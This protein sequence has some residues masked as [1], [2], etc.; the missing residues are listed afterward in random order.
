[1]DKLKSR[2]LWITVFFGL[3]IALNRVLGLNFSEE[4]II[5][6]AG[7]GGAYSAFQGAIDWKQAGG[8][9]K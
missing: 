5:S 9:K 7:L 1:M 2:K 4:T 6:L 8:K 3:A